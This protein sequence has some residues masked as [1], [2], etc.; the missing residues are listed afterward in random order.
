[1]LISAQIWV[2]FMV[3]AVFASKVITDDDFLATLGMSAWT[4]VYFHSEACLYC[5]KFAPQFETLTSLYS[6]TDAFQI[7]EVNGP[8]NRKLTELFHVTQYPT[9]MLLH[10][11]SKRLV[12]YTPA[13][14]VDNII[15]Y[16]RTHVGVLPQYN[17]TRVPLQ[18]L[19]DDNFFETVESGTE[20]VIAFIAPHL[21][22]WDDYNS[23]NHFFKKPLYV[24]D[25]Q[26]QIGVV[27]IDSQVLKILQTFKISHVPSIMYVVDKKLKLYQLPTHLDLEEHVI[28]EFIENLHE[29]TENYGTWYDG[30]SDPRLH[31]A[32][33]HSHDNYD[34][35]DDDDSDESFDHIEL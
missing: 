30:T 6:D 16:I 25:N 3:N 32:D 27:D 13:R 34:N 24:D 4:F 8:R 2:F 9:I 21:Y 17:E 33:T 14:T 1:M 7:V 15:E 12:Q 23:P 31:N 10:Y 20:M 22:G 26:V 5:S 18:H 29:E 28:T 35:Y 19:D 11:E